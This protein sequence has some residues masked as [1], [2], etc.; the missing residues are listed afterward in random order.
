[1]RRSLSLFLLAVT[2]LPAAARAQDDPPEVT[3]ITLHPANEPVPALKYRILPEHRDQIPG[4]AAIFYHRA[5]QMVL[6][7]RLAASRQPPGAEKP[8]EANQPEN[9][10]YEWITGPLDQIPRDESRELLGRY[11][12]PLHEIE[13]GARRQDCDWEFEHR[14]ETIELLIPDIQE[15]RTLARL[16]DLRVRVA[17]LD[18]KTDEAIYWLQTGYAMS[19]HVNEGPFLIASLVGIAIADTMNRSLEEL[20][21]IPDTPNLYWAI[22]AS[23]RPFIDIT[24]ALEGERVML[25]RFFPS[26]NELDS[27]PWSIE[28]G[29]QFTDEFQTKFLGFSRDLGLNNWLGPG[30]D[31]DWLSRLGM[32]AMVAKLYPD[33]KRALIAE[34]RSAEQIEAMPTVQVVALHTLQQYQQIRDDMFKWMNLPYWQSYHQSD[35]A[36]R[37]HKAADIRG[38]PLLTLFTMF[39]PAVASGRVAEVRLDRQL[40]AIQC[41]EAIR[42]HTATHESALP[43]NL[44]AITDAPAPIDPATGKPFIYRVNGGIATLSAPLIPGGPDHPSFKLHYELRL[45]K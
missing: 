29:R 19:R 38:N 13:L 32:A 12:G 36:F 37:N 5:I 8:T 24:P 41:I 1:M 40:A 22:A 23:P 14:P 2:T 11:R 43:P 15:M 3:V 45:A 21:Q 35:E 28:R 39:L 33:A 30:E 4:N 9:Q 10:L 25:E 16:V 31:V 26:L 27:A 44:E 17:I 18:G 6:E 7:R 20:I 34:G 42:L